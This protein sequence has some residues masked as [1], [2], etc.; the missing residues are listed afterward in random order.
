VTPLAEVGKGQT[1]PEVSDEESERAKA[2]DLD[3]L[4]TVEERREALLKLFDPEPVMISATG[5]R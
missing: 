2:T 1:M 3:A 5:G 4:S